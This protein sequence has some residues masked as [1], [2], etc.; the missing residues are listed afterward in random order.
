MS[1]LK[2]P[3][4]SQDVSPAA[5]DD[6]SINGNDSCDKS[7]NS[8]M[9]IPKLQHNLGCGDSGLSVVD[10]VSVICGSFTTFI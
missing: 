5:A 4:Q 8:M 2:D 3:D 10:E 1:S 7:Q 9:P 6:V